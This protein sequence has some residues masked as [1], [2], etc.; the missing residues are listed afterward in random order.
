M[1]LLRGVGWHCIYP[2]V[3]LVRAKGWFRFAVPQMS[4]GMGCIL[5]PTL[6][7]C[8]AYSGYRLGLRSVLQPDVPTRTYEYLTVKGRGC[9]LPT[10]H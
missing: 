1:L 6:G 8:R 9:T 4:H 2:Q 3:P 10:R 5:T 7:G